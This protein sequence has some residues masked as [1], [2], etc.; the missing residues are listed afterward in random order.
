MTVPQGL[1]FHQHSTLLHTQYLK[2]VLRIRRDMVRIRI[3]GTVPLTKNPDPD[4]ANFSVT[5]QMATKK[6][7]F[8]LR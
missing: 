3:R 5:F 7:L 1:F 8:A 2:A 4:P 6:N